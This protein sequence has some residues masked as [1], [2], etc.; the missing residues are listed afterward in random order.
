M[1]KDNLPPQPGTLEHLNCQLRQAVLYVLENVRWP[2]REGV[3]MGLRLVPTDRWNEPWD[4]TLN[5]PRWGSLS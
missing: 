5:A 4:E 1:D 2:W 3:R